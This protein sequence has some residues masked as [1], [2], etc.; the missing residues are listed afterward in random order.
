[1]KKYQDIK[2]DPIVPYEDNDYSDVTCAEFGT[3]KM[4]S[5]GN[6]IGYNKTS[7]M[8]MSCSLHVICP[9]LAH[10]NTREIKIKE[11]KEELNQEFFLDESKIF[12]IQLVD[13]YLESKFENT[14]FPC[15]SSELL[16]DFTTAN[17]RVFQSLDQAI[18]KY[19]L[20]RFCNNF[21]LVPNYKLHLIPD[22]PYEI[23]RGS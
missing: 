5:D 23:N 20:R 4:D 14:V 9:M 16:T 2:F 1:M 13:Q 10:L 7:P 8:C 19:L 15:N 12:N 22:E 21:N 3:R 18:P 17:K 6:I 11:I